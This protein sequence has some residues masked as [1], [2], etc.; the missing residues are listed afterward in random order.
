MLFRC[1]NHIPVKGI[2]A[3]VQHTSCTQL[4]LLCRSHRQLYPQHCLDLCLALRIRGSS[5]HLATVHRLY[6]LVSHRYRVLQVNSFTWTRINLYKWLVEQWETGRGAHW[7][8]V[9]YQTDQNRDPHPKSINSQRN[10]H[11]RNMDHHRLIAEPEHRLSIYR[12]IWRRNHQLS[13]CIHSADHNHRLVH[14]GEHSFGQIRPLHG[15]SI[16]R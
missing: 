9:I 2:R 12:P 3:S 4:V 16:S 6:Q 15:F 8:D 14:S 13:L 10:R 11:L 7:P 1:F 5:C